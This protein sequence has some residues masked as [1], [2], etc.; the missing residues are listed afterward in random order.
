MLVLRGRVE[1]FAQQHIQIVDGEGE[2]G[3]CFRGVVVKR[4]TF[5]L[6]LHFAEAFAQ[7]EALFGIT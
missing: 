2:V 3:E 1:G 4:T 5:E 7:G 6:A